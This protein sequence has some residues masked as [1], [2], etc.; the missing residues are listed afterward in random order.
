MEAFSLI[1]AMLINCQAY[2]CVIKGFISAQYFLKK[3]SPEEIWGF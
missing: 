2:S 1:P 3:K